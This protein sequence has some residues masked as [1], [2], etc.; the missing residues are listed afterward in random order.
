MLL[1][2][3]NNIKYSLSVYVNLFK[4][5]LFQIVLPMFFAIFFRKLSQL[6]KAR[7]EFN[8]IRHERET[9]RQEILN[10]RQQK[11]EKQRLRKEKTLHRNKMLSQKTRKGQP[12]MKPRMQLLLEKINA[13]YGKK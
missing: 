4:N 2:N 8:S 1:S 11:E 5:A 9:Q 13:T 7:Q 12:L 3:Y 6:S 10:K